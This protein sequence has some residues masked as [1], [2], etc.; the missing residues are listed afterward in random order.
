MRTLQRTIH[1]ALPYTLHFTRNVFAVGNPCLSDAASRELD[2]QPPT[3]V[4]FVFDAGLAASRPALTARVEAYCQAWRARI[5]SV[6]IVQMPGGEAAKNDAQRIAELHRRIH[7]AK[8]CRHSFVCIV[9]GGAVL[10]AAGFAA[11]TAHR[12]VRVIRLPTTVLAQADA[13]IGVKNGVNAFGKKNFI[14]TFAVPTAVINDSEFLT[15]L[16]LRD[17]RAGLAEAV[18]VAVLKDAHFFAFLERNAAALA[19]RDLRAMEQAVARCAELHLDHIVAGGD[20]FEFGSSRPLDFGHWAAHKLEQLSDH[21]LRHG[22]AVAIGIALDSLYAFLSGEL[23]H[24]D[25]QRILALLRALGF[26]LYAPELTQF[27]FAPAHSRCVLSGLEEFREHLGGELTVTLAR[28]IG[29]PYEV[30]DMDRAL[31]KRA[32]ERLHDDD[33]PETTHAHTD[34]PQPVERTGT[35]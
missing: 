16:D 28:A 18:K 21:R 1:L 13:G 20:P 31:I 12:G 11:A 15:S 5:D 22:E 35:D 19:A 32:I 30:H 29:A 6:G 14:G 8:L 2:T 33:H 3:K 9:G 17:W 4:L 24:R 26:R 27:W 34:L 10:D 7:D 23:A 25:C